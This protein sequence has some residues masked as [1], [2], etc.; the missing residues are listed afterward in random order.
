MEIMMRRRG[1]DELLE[2]MDTNVMEDYWREYRKIE[3][4]LIIV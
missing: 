4:E 1:H 2:V 3:V